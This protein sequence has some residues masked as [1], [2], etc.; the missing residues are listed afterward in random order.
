MFQRQMG[1]LWK[2]KQY[3]QLH[4]WFIIQTEII[5]WNKKVVVMLQCDCYC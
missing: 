5:K 4:F 3:E 1:K 2:G